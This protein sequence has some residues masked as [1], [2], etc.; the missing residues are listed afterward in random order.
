MEYAMSAQ[1]AAP[2]C[3]ACHHDLQPSHSIGEKNGYDLLSCPDCRSVTVHPFP[4]IETL[5]EYYQSYKGTTD[6]RA[7]AVK[8]IKRAKKRIS[9]LAAYTSGK[10]FLDVGCNYG[11]SVKAAA[12]L[13]LDAKGIDI[14]ETAITESRKAFSDLSFDNISIEDYAAQG[15]KADIIYTSEVIEHVHNPDSFMQAVSKTLSP[16]GILYLTT[17]D[18]GHW[19]VPANFSDWGDVMPP[20]HIIYFTRKGMARLFEK[21]GLQPLKFYFA[22]KPGIRAIARKI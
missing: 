9:R 18:A 3:K 5:I 8:K 13:G 4:T 21:H 22:L 12:E 17:P 7:K 19:R 1:N 14:D 2:Y 11:F 6:Y 15:N 10:N 20:E 16:N